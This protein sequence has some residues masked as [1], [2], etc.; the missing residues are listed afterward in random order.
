MLAMKVLAVLF[1]LFGIVCWLFPSA[2]G[3]LLFHVLQINAH[4]SMVIGALF[5]AGALILFF[6]EPD[7]KGL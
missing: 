2:I 4:E 7:D 1:G 3:V 5:F 6:I